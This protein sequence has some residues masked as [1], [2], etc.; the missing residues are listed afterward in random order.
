VFDA[1]PRNNGWMVI[2]SMERQKQCSHM[3]AA[4]KVQN[5]GICVAK[6]L[7]TVLA[8]AF[9]F[10]TEILR[11]FELTRISSKFQRALLAFARAEPQNGSII[12][13]VHHT[14]ASWEIVTA[15]R[16]FSGFGHRRF[17]FDNLI[18]CFLSVDFLGFS[19][20]FSQHQ[21]VLNSHWSFDISR[22]NSTLFSSF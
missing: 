14:R 9:L 4:T 8:F 20:G 18:T 13:D 2:A 16:A 12:L 21:N 3:S 22:Y 5:I 15:K 17:L 11:P 6:T 10:F 1:L 7:P 19:L